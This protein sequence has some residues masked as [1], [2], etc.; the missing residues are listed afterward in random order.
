M[1]RLMTEAQYDA[2]QAKHRT[3][4]EP[5]PYV[6]GLVSLK[7]IFAPDKQSKVSVKPI[8]KQ[9][10]IAQTRI[11][12][13]PYPPSVNT[14]WRNLP[15]GRTVLS[16]RAR[17]YRKIVMALV[18]AR[19][20]LLKRLSVVIELYPPDKRRRDIDNPIKAVF[21]SLQHA[22]VYRDDEQIDELLVK[23]MDVTRD[24]HCVVVIL[25]M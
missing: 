4:T 24:G 19:S 21:D 1:S 6:A 3:L 5:A 20:P 12:E 15:T 2:R 23:R 7:D 11:Y 17:A 10:N 22:G 13:L 14:Y 18:G 9:I 16:A 8:T 25:D